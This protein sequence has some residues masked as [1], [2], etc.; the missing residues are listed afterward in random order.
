MTGSPHSIRRIRFRVWLRAPGPAYFF[1]F[2]FTFSF[3]PPAPFATA[4]GG[5][6]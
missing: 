3:D 4:G 6:A 1:A 5:S 2:A